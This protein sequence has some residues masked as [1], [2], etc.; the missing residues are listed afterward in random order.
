M[1]HLFSWKLSKIALPRIVPSG[2]SNGGRLWGQPPALLQPPL[3]KIPGSALDIPS[4][5]G[6]KGNTLRM[7]LLP[8]TLF[9]L[10]MYTFICLE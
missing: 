5:I 4:D 10:S 9:Y 8:K 6:E 7:D 3:K 2:G 1:G